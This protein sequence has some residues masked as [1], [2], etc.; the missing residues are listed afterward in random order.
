[1]VPTQLTW[2]EKWLAKE[3]ESGDTNEDTFAQP[4]TEV[5]AD[6]EVSTADDQIER[7]MMEVNMVFIIPDEFCAPGSEVAEL[8]PW[9]ERAVFEKLEQG[10]EHMKP[11]FVKGHLNGMSVGCMMIDEGASVNIMPL[12]MFEK[13][14]H[15][16]DDSKKTNLSLS[17]FS[18]EL[19]EA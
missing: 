3:D 6:E 19:A 10:G 13:L 1:M 16:E 15:H 11:L 8:N 14:G 5:V 17:G 18:G 12:W 2:K 4:S 7:D 9:V